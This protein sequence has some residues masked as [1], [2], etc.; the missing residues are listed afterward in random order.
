MNKLKIQIDDLNEKNKNL[1]LKNVTSEDEI[2]AAN[3]KLCQ[4]RYNYNSLKSTLKTRDKEIKKINEKLSNLENF[5]E[6]KESVEKKLIESNKSNEYL[7][8][9]IE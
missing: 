6:D 7:K 1:S 8:K 3:D 5:A 9:E 2:K 4:S